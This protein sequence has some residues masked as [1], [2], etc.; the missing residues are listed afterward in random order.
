MSIQVIV[1]GFDPFHNNRLNPS[2]LAVERMPSSV[3]IDEANRAEVTSL[4][5][6]TCCDNAWGALKPAVDA[7]AD[8]PFFVL[9]TGLAESRDHICLERFGLNVRYYRGPDNSGHVHHDEYL[10][11]G[12]DAIRTIVPLFA[13][14]DHLRKKRIACDISNHAG[15][16]I[17]NETY[18]RSL[19]RW[20]SD[21]NCRGVLFV[22]VPP[23]KKY[24]KTIGKDMLD[25]DSAAATYAKVYAEI[26]KFVCDDQGKAEP[27]TRKS[28]AGKTS[29]GK[30]RK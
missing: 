1:T 4:V 17:C 25:R 18:Y 20:Q 3:K 27:K 28:G 9:I 6:P 21:K 5:L 19:N 24:F 26:I 29:A 16:F 23:F 22:H 30:G 15:S 12:P 11:D 13:L 8:Q 2:Q 10:E 7:V 14:A